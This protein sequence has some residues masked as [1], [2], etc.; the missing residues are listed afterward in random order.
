MQAV[1]SGRATNQALSRPKGLSCFE[2]K[3]SASPFSTFNCMVRSLVWGMPTRECQSVW[4][5]PT[6]IVNRASEPE[7]YV[8]V[9]EATPKLSTGSANMHIQGGHAV[10]LF[11]LGEDILWVAVCGVQD[12]IYCPT[13]SLQALLLLHA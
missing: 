1:G 4:G 5:L 8:T 10:H 9:G 7:A 2:L 12:Q 13:H 11:L 3:L 6:V